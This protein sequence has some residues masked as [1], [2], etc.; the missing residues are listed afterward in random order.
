M[1]S[2]FHE[3]HIII[4]MIIRTMWQPFYNDILRI[5][6]KQNYLERSLKKWIYINTNFYLVWFYAYS[7][8]FW[9]SGGFFPD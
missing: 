6:M 9:S 7:I 2:H 1:M 3:P 8:T 4:G 5:V